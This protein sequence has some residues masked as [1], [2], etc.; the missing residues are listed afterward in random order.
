MPLSPLPSSAPE[1]LE[2]APNLAIKLIP[3]AL[4]FPDHPG[5]A[6]VVATCIQLQLFRGFRFFV[7]ELPEEFQPSDKW[8]PYLLEHKVAGH[9]VD[10]IMLR[11]AIE[12]TGEHVLC[13]RWP[14]TADQIRVAERETI[15]GRH[16]WYSFAPEKHTDCNN[17][18]TWAINVINR[19]L[20]PV[21][22]EIPSGR[23]K[24]ATAMLRDIGAQP[25]A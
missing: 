5:H 11:D 12:K 15:T 1:A 19:V 8:R 25:S 17:C 21:L 22:P 16:G 23:I 6:G 20:G 9:V 2:T 10:D 24:L 13:K 14:A 3:R 18:V 4:L 7:L